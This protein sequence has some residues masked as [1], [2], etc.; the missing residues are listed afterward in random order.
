MKYLW[1][2]STPRQQTVAC[3][4]AI[5]GSDVLE[6]SVLLLRLRRPG[7]EKQSETSW[8]RHQERTLRAGPLRSVSPLIAF[9]GSWRATTKPPICI[10]ICYFLFFYRLLKQM[11]LFIKPFFKVLSKR[12]QLRKCWP[13]TDPDGRIPPQ[14]ADS[15]PLRGESIRFLL[16]KVLL[17]SLIMLMRN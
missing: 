5:L 7:E 2:L 4:C 14:I 10:P 6:V 16:L 3:H 8:K 12:K 15:K 13:R 1:G 11:N 17:F 9:T